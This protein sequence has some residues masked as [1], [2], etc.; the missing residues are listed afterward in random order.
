MPT[1]PPLKVGAL[2]RAG[3]RSWPERGQYMLREDGH[4]LALFFASPSGREADV[5][6]RGDV[7]LGVLVRGAVIFFLYRFGAA[8]EIDWSDAPFSIHRV[9]AE[10]RVDPGRIGALARLTVA[11]V[12]ATSGLVR[13]LRRLSLP[14]AFSGALQAALVAQAKASYDPGVYSADL[15]A[16]Y[17]RF[18]HSRQMAARAQRTAP[19]A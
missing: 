12:D 3:R 6:S 14:P 1:A 18:A 10:E 19:S 11:L 2:Y 15:N 8:G 9:P 7:E 5:V 17:D 16:A 13:A 4:E